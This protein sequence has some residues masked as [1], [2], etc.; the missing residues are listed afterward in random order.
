MVKL[1]AKT[2]VETLV[3]MV[4]ISTVIALWSQVYLRLAA[5]PTLAQEQCGR[6][7]LQEV[8]LAPKIGNYIIECDHQEWE[9]SIEE[10]KDSG[11]YIRVELAHQ[12]PPIYYQ[13]YAQEQD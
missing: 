9:I 3:A 10:T 1:P 6:Q 4:I 12:T 11:R 2:L 8:I 5:Q 13:A 7:L